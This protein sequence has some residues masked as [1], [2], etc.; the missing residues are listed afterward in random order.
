MVRE[1]R[2]DDLTE[3]D[4]QVM[5]LYD[6]TKKPIDWDASDDAILALSR[7][8]HAKGGK[9]TIAAAAA[10]EAEAS[11][12]VPFAPRQRSFVHRV[13]HSPAMGFSLA[14]SLMIGV[15]SGQVIMPYVDLGI[16]PGYDDVVR[17]NKRLQQELNQS[18]TMLTRSLSAHGS[19]AAQPAGSIMQLTQ[20]LSGFDCASLSAALSKDMKITVSGYVSSDADLRQLGAKLAGLERTAEIINQATV[21]GKPACEVLE[22]LHQKAS[23]DSSLPALP[24]I[25]PYQHGAAYVAG[26]KLVV[27]AEATSLYDG[28]LYVDFIQHD[29]TVLH[30]LPGSDKATN[31]VKAGERVRLGAGS[32]EYTIAPPYGTEILTVISSPAPLFNKARPQIE[33]A[34]EYLDALRRALETASKRSDLPKVMSGYQFVKTGPEHATGGIGK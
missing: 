24:V 19:T 6:D 23:A 31:T 4:R 27:E 3:A 12:V 7:E 17:D 1:Q 5:R 22:L 16:S 9:E 2:D 34:K 28:Y 25:R 29:G 33:P 14:A 10:P 11:T 32:Q 26:E 20:A 13:I 18:Q 8:I 30:M 21:A 15:F